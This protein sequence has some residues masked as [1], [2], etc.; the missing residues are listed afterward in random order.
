M[1]DT[2]IMVAQRLDRELRPNVTSLLLFITNIYCGFAVIIL[3]SVNY[4]LFNYLTTWFFRQFFIVLIWLIRLICNK[5]I[6]P[7]HYHKIHKVFLP[8]SV[9][10]FCSKYGS[11]FAIISEYFIV[12]WRFCLYGLPA[13]AAYQKIECVYD[14]IRPPLNLF[15]PCRFIGQ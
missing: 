9:R 7:Y 11:D 13:D 3:N 5:R 12:T 14:I 10:A 15:S 2:R 4:L 8:N 6:L 1:T